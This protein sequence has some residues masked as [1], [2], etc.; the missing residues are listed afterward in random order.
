M[1]K[2]LGMLLVFSACSAGSPE[3]NKPAAVPPSTALVPTSSE[4]PALAANT[5]DS[6]PPCKLT[7]F[8]FT[9]HADIRLPDKKPAGAQDWDAALDRGIRLPS[10]ETASMYFFGDPIDGFEA[11]VVFSNGSKVAIED[12][13]GFTEADGSPAIVDMTLADLDGDGKQELV[14]H[15]WTDMIFPSEEPTGVWPEHHLAVIAMPQRKLALDHNVSRS[16]K[17]SVSSGQCGGESKTTFT[18]EGERTEYSRAAGS[19]EYQIVPPKK[20]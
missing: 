18:C 12:A 14:I 15:Y 5:Q 3:P 10:G 16:K 20:Q 8:D 19:I 1:T 6:E 11:G 17:W 7:T 2:V 13:V 4:K 9:K